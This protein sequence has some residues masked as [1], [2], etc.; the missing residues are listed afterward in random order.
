LC[1][2]V[3]QDTGMPVFRAD[4]PLTCVAFG[5][6]QALEHFDH[7]GSTRRGPRIANMRD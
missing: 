6:G 2:L 4:S 7:F 5:S 1:E 3:A